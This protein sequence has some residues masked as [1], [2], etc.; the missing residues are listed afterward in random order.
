MEKLIIAWIGCGLIGYL[1]DQIRFRE[2]YETPISFI[3]GFFGG[4]AT[5]L[6][7]WVA[8]V[9]TPANNEMENEIY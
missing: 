6:F 2:E 9:A 8:I 1:I 5:I 7:V 3:R 4:L